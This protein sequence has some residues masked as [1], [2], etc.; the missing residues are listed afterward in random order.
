MQRAHRVDA[1]V[2]DVTSQITTGRLAVGHQVLGLSNMFMLDHVD[3]AHVCVNN[4]I[5]IFAFNRLIV[6][7]RSMLTK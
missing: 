5:H 2:S 7:R 3:L 4:S 1:G 6:V